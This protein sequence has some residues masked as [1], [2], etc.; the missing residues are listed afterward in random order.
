MRFEA[1]CRAK[2]LISD[3]NDDSDEEI[4][5]L[6]KEIRK[7]K[8]QKLDKQQQGQHKH[9]SNT[10]TGPQSGPSLPSASKL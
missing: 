6:Q 4:K 2:G 9:I 3:S 1:E 7:K 10:H 5:S 8:F